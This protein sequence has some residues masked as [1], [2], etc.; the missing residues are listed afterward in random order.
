MGS[1]PGSLPPEL[2]KS[3]IINEQEMKELEEDL[4]KEEKQTV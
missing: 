4:K 2:P 3:S 1:G